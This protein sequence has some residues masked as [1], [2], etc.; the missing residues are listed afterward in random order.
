MLRNWIGTSGSFLRFSV[1]SL[2]SRAKCTFMNEHDDKL[3]KASEKDK[4]ICS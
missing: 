2:S 4:N 3:N 1:A